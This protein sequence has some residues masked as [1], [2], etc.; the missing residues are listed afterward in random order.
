M[1]QHSKAQSRQQTKKCHEAKSDL[2]DHSENDSEVNLDILYV[3][4]SNNI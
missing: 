1:A 3:V 2:K 4:K